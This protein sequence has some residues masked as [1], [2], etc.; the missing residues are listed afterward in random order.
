MIK[1]LS[2][3]ILA[4]FLLLTISLSAQDADWWLNEPYRLVQTNLREID[5]AD[6]DMKVY[7]ESLQDMGANTVL[8]NVG[9]IVANYYTDLEF[10][11]RNP[12]LK[13]DLIE[14]LIPKLHDAGIRVMGRFDFSKLNEE[15]ADKNPDWLYVNIRGE[16]V[17]YNHQV[18]TSVNGGYQQEYA[19]KILSE[20]LERFPLDNLRVELFIEEYMD[21]SQLC[22]E[23]HSLP[24]GGTLAGPLNLLLNAEVL[25]LIE[26]NLLLA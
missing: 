11:Y 10:H 5:A 20:A 12:N 6:F 3:V 21:E 24:P 2:S 23:A 26:E 25:G 18:H 16:Y 1:H 4:L 13:F 22:L 19:F 15:M 7:V 14:E 8:I 9:G 17:N